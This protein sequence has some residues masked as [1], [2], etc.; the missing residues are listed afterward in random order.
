MIDALVQRDGK[1]WI[2]PGKL[3]RVMNVMRKVVRGLCHKYDEPIVVTDD[4]VYVDILTFALPPGFEDALNEKYRVEN[5]VTVRGQ[6]ID[7]DYKPDGDS[8]VDLH[9]VWHIEFCELPFVAAVT[10]GPHPPLP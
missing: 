8:P 1:R 9:S 2:Y 4:Q 5:V 3:E 7:P 6:I 10:A